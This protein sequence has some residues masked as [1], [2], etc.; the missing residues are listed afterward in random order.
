MGPWFYWD[1]SL[2]ARYKSHSQR[3]WCRLKHYSNWL[4]EIHVLNCAFYV[5]CHG[6]RFLWQHQVVIVSITVAWVRHCSD[7]GGRREGRGGGQIELWYRGNNI[8]VLILSM[9][10]KTVK[11]SIVLPLVV[12]ILT[13]CKWEW[14][15]N[16]NHHKI[17]IYLLNSTKLHCILNIDKSIATWNF[18]PDFLEMKDNYAWTIWKTA[19][20]L[21]SYAM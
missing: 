8:V 2:K 4:L 6:F 15:C 14:Q 13:L 7:F 21:L 18:K 5:K 16:N 12:A 1:C 20:W 19:T 11:Y 9:H 10:F 3:H 17:M